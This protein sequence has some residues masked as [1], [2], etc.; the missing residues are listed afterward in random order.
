MRSLGTKYAVYFNR[1]YKRVGPLFQGNYKAV[2]VDTEDQLIYLTKY[3]HKNPINILPTGLDLVGY[4]YSSYQNYLG[5]FK[6]SW[7]KPEKILEFF[8]QEGNSSYKEFVEELD[9][10]NNPFLDKLID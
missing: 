9:D 7:V 8:T 10:E 1:K 6:Q 2:K 3:I 5:L 4:K